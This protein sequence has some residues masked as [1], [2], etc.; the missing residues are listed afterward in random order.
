MQC[1]AGG[2]SALPLFEL[3]RPQSTVDPSVQIS[4]DPR[5]VGKLEV[6]SPTA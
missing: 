5:G 6:L 2:P 4:E 1:P 3:Q